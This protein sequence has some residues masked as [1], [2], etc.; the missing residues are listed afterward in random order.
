MTKVIG[1]KDL[2]QRNFKNP[3]KTGPAGVI[4]KAF[5]FPLS[6][7]LRMQAS[8]GEAGHEEPALRASSFGVR[9]KH[10]GTLLSLLKG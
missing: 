2:P 7:W 10:S 9:G 8:A 5:E 4:G 6:A 3:S 1:H